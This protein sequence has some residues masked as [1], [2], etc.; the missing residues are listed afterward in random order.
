MKQEIKNFLNL[1]G[2][3]PGILEYTFG[4]TAILSAM[5][6]IITYLIIIKVL[7]IVKFIYNQTN[8]LVKSVWK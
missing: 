3:K 4:A 8:E 7:Q 2:S 1:W 6:S 5:P